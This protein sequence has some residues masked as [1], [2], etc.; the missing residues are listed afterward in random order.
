MDMTIRLK[1]VN[2]Y[3]TK[4]NVPVSDY[5]I[6]PYIG[7]PH[8]CKYCYACFMKRFT[9]HSEDWGCFLDV[10]LCHKQLPVK[11]L[12]GKSI[13][14]ATVTDC[15][16]PYEETYRI[17]RNILE[18]LADVPCHLNITTKSSLVLR[19]ID[20]LKRCKNVEVAISLNTLNEQFR[21]DMDNADTVENRIRALREL[22]EEGIY[23]ILFMAPM[24]PG[25]TDFEA[26]IER[27]QEYVSEYWFENLNLRGGFKHTIISYIQEKF[28]DLLPLYESIYSQ[29]NTVYWELLAQE[30]ESYCSEHHI[31]HT[32]YFYHKKL[33]QEKKT[34]DI[35]RKYQ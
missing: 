23:T 10:K 17:T 24:F 14:M 20:L 31:N 3:L 1:E 12:E 27:T 34:G 29:R 4:S 13:F 25:I 8:G 16:N 19:D 32:N 15:Y 33:V 35:V 5:A 22:H 28:P 11:K 7:C 21:C 9:G 18:Q 2:S 26:L 6:N 30:I